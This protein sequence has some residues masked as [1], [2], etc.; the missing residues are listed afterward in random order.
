MTDKEIKIFILICVLALVGLFCGC[1][2][3]LPLMTDYP[4]NYPCYAYDKC[5]T[6]QTY[7]SKEDC[8]IQLQKCFIYTDMKKCGD[9]KDC[10]NKSGIRY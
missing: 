6:L 2:P 7:G 9:D 8:K 10:W 3:S 5:I 1:K 4:E